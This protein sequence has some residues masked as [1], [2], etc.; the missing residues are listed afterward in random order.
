MAGDVGDNPFASLSVNL[1]ERALVRLQ[2][3]LVDLISTMSTSS[4]K[5]RIKR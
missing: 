3:L 1:R 5:P 2:F 4:P